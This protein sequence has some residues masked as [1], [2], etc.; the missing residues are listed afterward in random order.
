MSNKILFLYFKQ[1]HKT[2]LMKCESIIKV[3]FRKFRKS[4]VFSYMQI[5]TS[6]SCREAF[7]K[8]LFEE[9]NRHHAVLI[10]GDTES[11]SEERTL[12]KEI[13]E[14]KASEH[15]TLGK[16]ICFPAVEK[17][18][19]S[20]D[21][22]VSEIYTASMEN[23]NYAA[24]LSVKLSRSRKHLLTICTKPENIV[25]TTLFHAVEDACNKSMHINSE[26]ISF[27][28]MIYLC[29]KTV[30]SFDT[31]LATEEISKVISAH[32][33]AS[34]RICSGHTV[35][36]TERGKFY[37]SRTSFAEEMSNAHFA[38][39]LLTFSEILYEEFNMKNACDWL[40]K[41]VA[42]SFETHAFTPFDEFS[43]KVISEIQKPMRYTR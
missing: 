12:F 19:K 17:T 4:V 39:V 2:E 35:L 37:M 5:D 41:A 22:S 13:L 24:E 26:H 3:L 38:S 1:K 18:F 28:R 34:A 6:S 11:F 33:D 25:D 23:L 9:I 43:D 40:R 14:L 27:D 36:H 10:K 15:H 21:N 31:V 20:S 32:L 16:V 42:T 30:P 29:T 8:V 7:M